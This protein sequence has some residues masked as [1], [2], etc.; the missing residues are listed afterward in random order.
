[1][2]LERALKILRSMAEDGEIDAGL[3][4]QFIQSRAWEGVL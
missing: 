1:M 4:N 3:L 2:P